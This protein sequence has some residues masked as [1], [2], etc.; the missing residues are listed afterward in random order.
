M[1]ISPAGFIEWEP[2][3]DDVGREPVSI[4]VRYNSTTSWVR[5]TYDLTV[6]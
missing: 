1:T 5:Q 6:Y 2:T 4:K 3:D